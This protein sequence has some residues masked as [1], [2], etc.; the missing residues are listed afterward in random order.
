MRLKS[1][2]DVRRLSSQAGFSL[3][4]ML[5]V[6]GIIG[7][8]VGYGAVNYVKKLTESRVS[9]GVQILNA[10]FK[11]ARQS[12]IAMRQSRRVVIY[13]GEL[14]GLSNNPPSLSGQFNEPMQIWIEGKICE[15][16]PFDA[17]ATCVGGN[18]REPNAYELTDP[19]NF[20]DG[21]LIA[22][23]DGRIP[24]YRGNPNTIC[25]EFSPRGSIQKVYFAGQESQTL[26]NEIQPVF[27]LIRTGEVFDLRSERGDYTNV[28]D[29]MNDQKLEWANP[30]TEESLERNKVQT[31]EIIRLT[32]KTR[33]YDYAIMNPW[34][35]D[36]FVK[37]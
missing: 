25:V 4:E 36:E 32:G 9:S 8:L 5:I 21:I 12:A 1:N 35:L 13:T 26:Y 2:P 14:S 29:E 16:Y 18:I 10:N 20:P 34:P 27:H 30:P 24:G 6:I 37:E 33:T 15:E 22:D 7:V 19:Q 3:T 31:I 23:V 11:Q 17:N 28:L